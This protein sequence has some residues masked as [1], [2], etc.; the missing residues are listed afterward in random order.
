MDQGP[1]VTEQLDAGAKLAQEFGAFMPLQAT[2]WLKERD[3][4]QWYLYLVSDQIDTNLKGAYGEVLRLLGKGSHFW[5]DP[6]QVKAVGSDNSL[7]KAVIAHQQQYPSPYP[8]RL[9][10]L[11]LGGVFVDEAVLYP[12]PLPALS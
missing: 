12:I 8:M 1:L 4:G 6:M 2:F 3:D 10:T 9:R 7:A 11:M 5:L